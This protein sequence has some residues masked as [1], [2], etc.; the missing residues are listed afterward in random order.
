[1]A[2]ALRDAVLAEEAFLNALFANDWNT[3][4]KMSETPEKRQKGRLSQQSFRGV[5][6]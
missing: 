6:H 2:I 1:V 5:I 3:A 4:A